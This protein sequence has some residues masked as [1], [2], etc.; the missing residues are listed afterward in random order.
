[1]GRFGCV[2]W[3][4]QN[5]TRTEANAREKAS[6]HLRMGFPCQREKKD[7]FARRIKFTPALMIRACYGL[8]QNYLQAIDCVRARL[9]SCGK[10]PILDSGFSH[11]EIANGLKQKPQG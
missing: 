11:S 6:V 4:E 5:G 10:G 9:Q 7:S 8:L 2:A 3:A 1:M